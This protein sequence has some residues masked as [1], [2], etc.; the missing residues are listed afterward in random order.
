V[1]T[2]AVVLLLAIVPLRGL[3]AVTVGFC[4]MGHHEAP[5]QAH[6]DHGAHDY[7]EAPAEPKGKADC[8]ICVEHCSS[9]SFAVPAP[10]EILLARNGAAR[11]ALREAFAAG[12]VPD[13]L[14]PPPLAH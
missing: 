14:D 10:A 13:H 6:A 1:K 4:A 7:H 5:A 11:I 8:N 9:A 12:F 2:L 3:A